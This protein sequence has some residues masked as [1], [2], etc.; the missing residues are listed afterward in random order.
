MRWR[1]GELLRGLQLLVGAMALSWIGCAGAAGGSYPTAHEMEALRCRHLIRVIAEGQGAGPYPD[2]PGEQWG[3]RC[4]LTHKDTLGFEVSTDHKAFRLFC[5]GD[6]H[7]R[8]GLPLNSPSFTSGVGM[9]QPMVLP[10]GFPMKFSYKQLLKVEAMDQGG[11]VWVEAEVDPEVATRE[12]SA[13]WGDPMQR[14][15]EKMWNN[16]ISPLT[17]GLGAGLK[18]TTLRVSY[19]PSHLA[20]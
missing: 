6:N 3:F 4:P 8:A 11:P 16:L 1:W 18:G 15:D 10:K 7:V 2:K 17:D 19:H 9:D 13:K 14:R 12:L 20:D 5:K